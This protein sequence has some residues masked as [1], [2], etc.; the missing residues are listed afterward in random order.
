MNGEEV[1]LTSKTVQHVD[2][3]T[4]A[5]QSGVLAIT[6]YRLIFR[7]ANPA[8][9][10]DLP[11]SFISSIDK[12]S[13]TS[14]SQNSFRLRITSK[15]LR[16]EV[17]VVTKNADQP[18]QKHFLDVL[19]AHAFPCR[20]NG[21]C[22]LSTTRANI[23]AKAGASTMQKLSINVRVCRTICGVSRISTRSTSCVRLTRRC[24]QFL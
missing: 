20:T 16:R 5:L 2:G 15:D 22:S 3:S 14:N 11:L 6:N 7:A 13:T 10:F 12:V 4:D 21:S 9:S 24:W 8:D 23:P 19:K 17:F 18:S 1:K